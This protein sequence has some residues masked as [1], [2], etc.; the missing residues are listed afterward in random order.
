MRRR[1]FIQGFYQRLT[2]LEQLPP[3]RTYGAAGY[4]QNPRYQV[5]GPITA[6]DGLGTV[7]EARYLRGRTTLPIKVCVPGPITFTL[8]L[9]VADQRA[10][11]RCVA[12]LVAIV[13]QEPHALQAAG[14]GYVQG[15]EP[16]FTTARAGSDHLVE[17]FNVT[18]EG[19]SARVGLYV[20][21]GNFRDR[22]D[23]GYVLSALA[24][25]RCDQ[26]DLEFANR[27]RAQIELLAQVPEP[28]DVG[29]G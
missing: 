9:E 8:P 14:V 29:V 26:I 4:D 16:R 25:L 21:F 3:L 22:L 7:A 23:Y 24:S 10:R 2:G 13:N 5:V 20:C 1:D 15:D 28:M 18:R 12:D 27:E 19:I 11:E 17:V 6:P